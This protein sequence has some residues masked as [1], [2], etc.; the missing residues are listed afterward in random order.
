MQTAFKEWFIV[1]D[2]LMRGEQIL[3]LRKGGISEGRGGFQVSQRSF[4]LFPTGFHQQREAV[5]DG[6]QMR[7]DL[8]ASELPSPDRLRLASF[9][10]VADVRKLSCIAD[11]KALR[12]QH[13]WRDK[14][15]EERFE[16]GKEQAIFAL[17]LRVYRLPLAI[18]LPMLSTYGGC[19]SWI[20]LGQEIDVNQATPVLSDAEFDGK[21]AA[22]RG[23]VD[24][25]RSLELPCTS[26]AASQAGC[27]RE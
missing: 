3:I 20:E 5:I 16:W 9:A 7:Y 4:F 12:G 1:V 13:I 25:A 19:K 14:V 8:I 27:C 24:E 15:I 2:A 10:E 22:F 21:L 11:A 6:A 26:E 18:E 23:A 17:A